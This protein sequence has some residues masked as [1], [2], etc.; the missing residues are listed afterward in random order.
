ME[1][2]DG[3]GCPHPGQ[4][5]LHGGLDKQDRGR[6]IGQHE[7]QLR[8]GIG[9]VQRHIGRPRADNGH[10]RHQRL[11]GPP[12]AECDKGAPSDPGP[13]EPPRQSAGTTLQI[14]IGQGRKAG[15]DRGNAVGVVVSRALEQIGQMAMPARRTPAALRP[16]CGPGGKPVEES[17]AQ[18]PM[19]L[20][21]SFKHGPQPPP[22]HW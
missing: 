9:R 18:H 16:G 10:N 21:M 17:V 6:G 4:P 22:K 7:G 13:G 1:Q 3:R 8:I 15:L 2:P 14:V 12:R 5:R 20:S 19:A 11:K